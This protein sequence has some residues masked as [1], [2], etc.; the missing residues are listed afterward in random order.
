MYVP[1]S[2][3]RPATAE[4][5]PRPISFLGENPSQA[6]R[7][8]AAVNTVVALAAVIMADFSCYS[9]TSA[10][11]ASALKPTTVTGLEWGVFG[12]AKPR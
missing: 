4:L 2:A 10:R 12:C 11:A 1:L 5:T 3:S 6:T 9:E 8:S 7:I